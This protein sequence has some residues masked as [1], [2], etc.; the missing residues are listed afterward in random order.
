MATRWKAH[1]VALSP[2]LGSPLPPTPVPWP[3]TPL[4]SVLAFWFGSWELPQMGRL[5][6]TGAGGGEGRPGT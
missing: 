2:A 3:T 5:G 6:H 4:C 1:G